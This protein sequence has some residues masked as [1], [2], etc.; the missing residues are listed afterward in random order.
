MY[1]KTLPDIKCGVLTL[2]VPNMQVKILKKIKSKTSEFI[3]TNSKDGELF[4][5]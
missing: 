2:T 4:L 3:E 1:K 5:L